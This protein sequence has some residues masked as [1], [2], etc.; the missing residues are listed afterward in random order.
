MLHTFEMFKGKKTGDESLD[1][2]NVTAVFK[3]A[4]RIYRWPIEDGQ[5]YLS[6]WG[7][8]L[9]DG[10]FQNFPEN[11]PLRY[12][13]RVYCVR[14]L[15][16]RPKDINGKSD[17]YLAIIL[18]DKQIVDRENIFMRNLNPVFGR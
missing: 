17:P 2:E 16:L 5:T 7:L 3:G 18:N 4:I 13:L 11:S 1:E 15:G 14:A 6:D 8:P 10:V 9:K 12:F